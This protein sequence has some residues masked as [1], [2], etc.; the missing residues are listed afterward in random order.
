MSRSV[1]ERVGKPRVIAGI[2][3][4]EFQPPVDLI[5][6][7]ELGAI[8]ATRRAGAIGAYIRIEDGLGLLPQVLDGEREGQVA[9]NLRAHADLLPLL[10]GQQGRVGKP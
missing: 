4:V 6:D 9:R 8:A 7:I 3:A 5:S 1:I 10:L 2:T